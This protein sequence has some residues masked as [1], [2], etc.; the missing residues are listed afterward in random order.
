MPPKSKQVEHPKPVSGNQPSIPADIEKSI[1]NFVLNLLAATEGYFDKTIINSDPPFQF[2]EEGVEMLYKSISSEEMQQIMSTLSRV[3]LTSKG[4]SCTG[5][6]MTPTSHSDLYFTSAFCY[7]F[8][9]V[10]GGSISKRGDFVFTAELRTYVIILQ[11]EIRGL[12][13]RLGLLESKVES[14]K[15]KEA[16]LE[17]DK[18][19]LQMQLDSEQRKRAVERVGLY[20]LP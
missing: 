16:S 10:G 5:G 12:K 13:V 7:Q 8:S 2:N 9:Y 6:E 3:H 19:F 14:L 18:K 1:Q 11:G 17:E 15:S 20:Y 4:I